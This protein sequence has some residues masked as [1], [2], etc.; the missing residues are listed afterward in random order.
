MSEKTREEQR[1]I[2]MIPAPGTHV[3]YTRN[4]ILQSEP[5]IILVYQ[6][7]SGTGTP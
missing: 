1:A 4:E 5:I 2:R 6:N 7:S 3:M